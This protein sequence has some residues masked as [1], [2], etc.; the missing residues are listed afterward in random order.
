MR[1]TYLKIS[2]IFFIS[3]L[4]FSC[5]K[6]GYDVDVSSIDTKVELKRFETKIFDLAGD[7]LENDYQQLY[8]EEPLIV[9]ALIEQILGAGLAKSPRYS[10]VR[11]FATDTSLLQVKADVLEEYPDISFLEEGL[12]DAFK[13]IQYHFPKDT[14]PTKAYTVVSGFA[15]PGFTYEGIL[16]VSLDWYMGEDYRFYH[17]QMMPKYMQRRMYREYIVPQVVKGYFTNKYPIREYTDGTLVSQMVYYGKLLEFTKMAMPNVPDSIIL[18]Y[19]TKNMNWCE[20]NEMQIFGHFVEKKLWYST[21]QAEVSKYF[22]DGPFT[23]AEGVVRSSA[24]RFGWWV[25]WNIVRNYLKNEGMDNL[26]AF[27]ENKDASSIFKKSKYKPQI[28]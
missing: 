23:S 27:Y 5:D 4:L 14:M 20:N 12:T 10:L 22:T 25:G 16:G 2:F 26:D 19:T 24:P 28:D 13:H 18:E 1:Q 6:Q 9:E 11:R 8:E 17:P 21:D 15:V 3:V 7:N